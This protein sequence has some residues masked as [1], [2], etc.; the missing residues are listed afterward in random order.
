M[1]FKINSSYLALNPAPALGPVGNGI[2][3]FSY[4]MYWCLLKMEVVREM[5]GKHGTKNS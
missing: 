4:I 2:S 1:L 3:S 5:S